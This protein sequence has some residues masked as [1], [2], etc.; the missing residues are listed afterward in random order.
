MGDPDRRRRGGCHEAEGVHRLAL[1]GVRA[2]FE[3]G[4]PH[5]WMGGGGCVGVRVN[6][7]G[8]GKPLGGGGGVEPLQTGLHSLDPPYRPPGDGP[9]VICD[10]GPQ[11]TVK[12]V[13]VGDAGVQDNSVCRGSSEKMEPLLTPANVRRDSKRRSWPGPPVGPGP[14]GG[15]GGTPPAPRR[16]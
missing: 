8:S 6:G 3:E 9:D 15:G 11:I 5:L 7:A 10:A 12:T 14:D 16:N 2:P 4:I 13:F 1:P